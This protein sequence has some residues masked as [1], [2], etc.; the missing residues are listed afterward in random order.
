MKNLSKD[1]KRMLSALAY[2][3]ADDYLSMHEKMA[4]L[5][6]ETNAG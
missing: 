6:Y 4:V 1:L 2:Q 5:A 3:D